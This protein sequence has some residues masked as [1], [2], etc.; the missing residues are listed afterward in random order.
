MKTDK[1][2]VVEDQPDILE[3]ITNIIEYSD[4]VEKVFGAT[5]AQMGMNIA[6]KEQPNLIISDWYMPDISG[7]E[8]IR[9]L[10]NHSLTRDIPIIICTGIMDSSYHLKIALDSGAADFI[11][12]PIDRIELI[13]RMQSVLK[14]AKLYDFTK[15]QKAIIENSHREITS[16]ITYASRIQNAILPTEENLQ[17]VLKNYFIFWKPRDIVSGDFYWATKIGN[18]IILAVADCTGH[19]VSGGFLSMLGIAFLNEIIYRKN[20]VSASEILEEMRAKV[21]N[22]LKQTGNTH[23]AGDG[24]DM[25][26]CIL[27]TEEN[28]LQFSGANL[29]LILIRNNE[30]IEFHPTRNPLG[31]YLLERNFENHIIPLQKNDVIYLFSDG[32]VD[33]FGGENGD[34]FMT[35][36]FKNL[37]LSIHSFEMSEQKT[38]LEKT[39]F[40]WM[41][42]HKQIDD[43]F[44]LGFKI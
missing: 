23:E 22:L 26:L 33:Q 4:I 8:F 17:S 21:K 15:Q 34:K 40:E 1:I 38:I 3:L 20:L 9:R 39:L 25:A 16:N 19:G 5:N 44:V 27:D 29:P 42:K 36:K 32:Y 30:L 35:R 18:Y 2:L 14:W 7:I 24:I 28:I 41:G 13:A 11:R 31:I 10:K 43:I 37:L 6:V 12:K